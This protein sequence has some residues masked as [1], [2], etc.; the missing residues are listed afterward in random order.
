MHLITKT[1]SIAIIGLLFSCHQDSS[2]SISDQNIPDS[3]RSEKPQLNKTIVDTGLYV[4][5]TTITHVYIDG[6]YF[7][8]LVFHNKYNEDHELNS[9]DE[10]SFPP[11]T[12]N[13]LDENTNKIVYARAQKENEFSFFKTGGHKMRDAGKQ[14]LAL[15][16][17]YGGSGFAGKLC[18]VSKSNERI[19]LIPITT[20]SVLSF[21]NFTKDGNEI[22]LLH[23]NWDMDSGET[24]F[25]KHRYNLYK[26]SFQ[27]DHYVEDSLGRTKYKYASLDDLIDVRDLMQEIKEKEPGFFKSVDINKFELCEI[28]N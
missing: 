20:Y 19:N 17:F 9:K 18:L 3:G 12:I 23:G 15:R 22:L 4:I 7:T 14:F 1:L 21:I 27:A 8:I 10:Y 6:G 26:Y 5:D 28:C 16:E 13:I 24:H 2:S 25:S 11:L